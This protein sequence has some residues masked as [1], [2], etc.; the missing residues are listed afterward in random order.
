MEVMEA[1]RAPTQQLNRAKAA[2]SG[3]GQDR[4]RG[5]TD[6]AHRRGPQG[7]LQTEAGQRRWREARQA[8]KT[9]LK[10]TSKTLSLRQVSEAGTAYSSTRSSSCCGEDGLARKKS[11]GRMKGRGVLSANGFIP[12]ETIS[13]KRHRPRHPSSWHCSSHSD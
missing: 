9:L 1:I 12:N 13:P 10:A 4:K 2:T 5:A 8:Q 6:P 7:C 3:G 11:T